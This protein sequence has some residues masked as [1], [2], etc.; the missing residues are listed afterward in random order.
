MARKKEQEQNTKNEPTSLPSII[1]GNWFKE[2]EEGLREKEKLD[3]IAKQRRERNAPRFRLKEGE[4]AVVVFL[5]DKGFYAKVHQLEVDGNFGNFITCIKDFAPCP[6]CNSGK[7][8]TY[9]AHYTILDGREFIRK[10]GTKVRWSK[11]IYPAKGSMINIIADLKKQFGSLV[12]RAFKVKR[13]TKQDPNCGNW[14]EHVKKIDISKY[15]DIKPF[16]Y[17]KVLAPPT[18]EEYEALGFGATIVGSEET[19]VSPEEL[20]GI[21]D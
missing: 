8:A 5:D 3:T 21:L 12:G 9:T 11:V 14:I 7:K 6:I 19:S 13:H 20:E 16:D 4:E 15:P 10:D 1:P 17:R 2:G 18:P